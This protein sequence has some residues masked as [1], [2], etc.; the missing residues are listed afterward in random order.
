MNFA[1]DTSAGGQRLVRREGGLNRVSEVVVNRVPREHSRDIGRIRPQRQGNTR[2]AECLGALLKEFKI[3]CQGAGTY[4]VIGVLPVTPP[5]R[6][7]VACLG[8]R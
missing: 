3:T 1:R 6:R 4:H 7:E 2:I 8:S 5:A